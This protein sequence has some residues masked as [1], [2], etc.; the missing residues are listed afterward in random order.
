VSDV[1]SQAE[2][3]AL[4]NA[5]SSGDVDTSQVREEARETQ[6]RV[7]DFMR[8][9]KFSKDQLRTLQ[10]LHESFCR[11]AQTQLSAQLRALVELSVVSADQVSYDEFVRSMPVPTLINIV[12]LEP[13]EG[14][15]VLEMNLP[16]VFSIVDRL[17]GGPGAQR[18][19]LRELTDIEHALMR[20]V[21]GGVL[22]ALTEA[23]AA[24]VPVQFAPIR[25]EMNPQF[26]QIVAPSEMVVLITLEARVGQASGMISLCIPYLTLEPAIGKFSAQSYFAGKANAHVPEIR[27]GLERDLGAV[28][29]PVTV[30]LGNAR[31]QVAD[32]LALAPGDVIPLDLPLGRDVRVR[33]AGRDA[34]RGQP[35]TRGRRV[36]VQITEA[37]ED[38]VAL[39]EAPA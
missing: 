16:L 34:F 22:R 35:G 32:L 39:E 31:L 25:A 17:V 33:V 4:L 20:N 3:D 36:A 27:A 6:V 10:M 9:S 15:A 19:K 23:W 14:S 5:I 2:I 1:L 13:L 7:F 26:A 18:P 29:V 21:T 37:V 24:V 11:I 12:A 38:L 30:E 8:P 28:D